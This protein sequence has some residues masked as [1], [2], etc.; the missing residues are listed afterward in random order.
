MIDQVGE[1]NLNVEVKASGSGEILRLGYDL[2]HMLISMR[3]YIAALQQ[4][5][6]ERRKLEIQT[7]TA[8]INPHFVKNTLNAIRITAEL[9]DAPVLAEQI[10]S[11]VGF[12]LISQVLKVHIIL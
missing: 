3:S 11:F 6:Q 1:G 4:K 10:R 9:S 5:E 7:L 2:N 12:I 8:Q